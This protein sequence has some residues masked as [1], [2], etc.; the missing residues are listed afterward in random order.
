MY[1]TFIFKY[2]KRK[3]RFKKTKAM[4]CLENYNRLK[5]IQILFIFI[6]WMFLNV[7]RKLKKQK[8][9]VITE[10]MLI[11]YIKFKEI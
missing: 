2:T 4:M 3:T 1:H 11:N 9:I 7:Y 5:K 6:F 10:L 8:N